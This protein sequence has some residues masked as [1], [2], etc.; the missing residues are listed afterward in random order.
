MGETNREDSDLV[1]RIAG[2]DQDALAEAFRD[3]SPA[4]KSLARRVVRDEAMAEDVVQEAFVWLWRSP[5]KYDSTR[6][7][8]RAFLLTVAHRRAVDLV[9]SEQARNRRESQPPDPVHSNLEDE[10]W[11]RRLSEQVRTALE[12][13]SHD[14]REAIS[15]AYYGGLSYVEVSRRLGQPEGTVKSRIRSGMRKLATTLEMGVS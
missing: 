14:E 8:L 7:S 12:D 5:D 3:F 9:R 15:L 6:G 10:V 1:R 2:G 4:V 11:S 13:L